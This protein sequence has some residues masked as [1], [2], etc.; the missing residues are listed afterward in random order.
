MPIEQDG[1]APYAPAGRVISVIERHRKSSGLPTPITQTVIERAGATGPLAPRTLKTLKLLDLVDADGNPTPQFEDLAKAKDSEY[2]DRFA[3]ILRAA[4]ADVFQFIDP[5][6]A[7]P[8][9]VRDQFRTYTPRGQQER[10]VAL[11]WGLCQYAGIISGTPQ[12]PRTPRSDKKPAATKGEKKPPAK[13]SPTPDP[14]PPEPTPAAQNPFI[15]GLL[16]SLP[17]VGTEWDPEARQKWTSAA[18][19]VFDLIYK[20][21]STKGGD[22]SD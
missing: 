10:M 20:L 13:P 16:Q 19:A 8:E 17:E 21:P 5:A 6:T 22:E 7:T 1:P 14:P 3:A 9:E 2:Q 18:L 4:Y 11:F 15:R 12:E